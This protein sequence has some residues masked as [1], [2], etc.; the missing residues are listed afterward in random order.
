MTDWDEW[1]ANRNA[2]MWRKLGKQFDAHACEIAAYGE[3]PFEAIKY[4]QAAEACYWQS[5]GEGDFTSL[6]DLTNSHKLSNT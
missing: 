2:R 1:Q 5:T 3:D 6:S 4:A